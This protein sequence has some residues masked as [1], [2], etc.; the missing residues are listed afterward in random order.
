MD[1]CVLSSSEVGRLQHYKL[2]PNHEEHGHID[3]KEAIKGIVDGTF[4][5]VEYQGRYFVTRAKTHFLQRKPSAGIDVIQRVVSN[6]I[7]EL[8]PV[9]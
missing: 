6:H 2:L 1:C 4:E 8:K 9:R 7:L 3:A 5:I